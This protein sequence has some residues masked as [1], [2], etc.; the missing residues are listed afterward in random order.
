MKLQSPECT[1]MGFFSLWLPCRVLNCGE[2]KRQVLNI[3][4]CS[5]TLPCPSLIFAQAVSGGKGRLKVPLKT[6]A[7][8]D[9]VF[10]S[11]LLSARSGVP[12]SQAIDWYQSLL[13]TGI[14]SR[15]AVGEQ[16]KLHLSLRLFPIAHITAWSP[17]PVRSTAALDSHRSKNPTALESSGNHPLSPSLWEKCLPQNR[18]LV[19][20]RLGS[21]YWIINIHSEFGTHV[22]DKAATEKKKSPPFMQCTF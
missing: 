14:H 20:K 12:N 17:L 22:G 5:V 3:S 19:P 4:W 13:G 11:F 6:V 9:N 2:Q 8:Q 16:A 7:T 15:W 10:S 1:T 21:L 18:A